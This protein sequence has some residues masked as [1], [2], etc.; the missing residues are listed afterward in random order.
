MIS[1]QTTNQ[2]FAR[3]DAV[4]SERARRAFRRRRLIGRV[5]AATPVILAAGLLVMIWIPPTESDAPPH[6]AAGVLPVEPMVIERAEQ[7]RSLTDDG[8]LELFPEG[9]CFLA[10]VNG[11][12]VLVF[13]DPEV[14]R[15]FF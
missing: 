10:E 7:A 11:R 4:V 14:K 9:S 6:G 2:R 12:K 5:L 8:L 1:N 13:H 15:R 3:H